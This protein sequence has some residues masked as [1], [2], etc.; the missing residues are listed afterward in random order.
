MPA[1]DNLST[2]PPGTA[3]AVTGNRNPVPSS[4]PNPR[5]QGDY[6]M[7]SSFRPAS[8][9]LAALLSLGA[10][11]AAMAASTPISV[12]DDHDWVSVKVAYADA[13]LQTAE[14]AKAL[15][16]RVRIAASAVCG[17]DNNLVRS[18]YR[19]QHCRG[20]AIARAVDALNA[21]LVAE[22]LGRPTGPSALARR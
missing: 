4:T 14:G 3:G 6:P 18:G 7:S 1:L 11:T 8:L 21:P 13:D 22:A 16:T 2:L 19:F 17:G 20:A 5:L 15:A 12:S 9:A 10:A